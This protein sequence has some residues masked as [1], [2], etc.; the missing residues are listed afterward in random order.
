MAQ[1]AGRR[2]GDSD[3]LI[4]RAIR[5]WT[6]GEPS[7]LAGSYLAVAR[8][9]P[10]HPGSTLPVLGA[11]ELTNW[12]SGLLV[13]TSP[14]ATRQPIDLIG[15]VISSDD[16]G[17]GAPTLEDVA[18]ELARCPLGGT[19][20]VLA[21]LLVR[22]KDPQGSRRDVELAFAAEVFSGHLLGQVQTRIRNGEYLFTAQL[23]HGTHYRMAAAEKPGQAGTCAPGRRCRPRTAVPLGKTGIR[24]PESWNIAARYLSLIHI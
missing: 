6:G 21:Q 5:A 22:L 10:T 13:P 3:E 12:P 9:G 19:V 7:G 14:R 16:V 4:E 2:P 20:K 1:G 24:R 23:A 15:L 11:R 18:A 17:L 8:P